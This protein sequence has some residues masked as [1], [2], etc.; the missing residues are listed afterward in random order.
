MRATHILHLGRHPKDLF[1]KSTDENSVDCSC[2]EFSLQHVM[3]FLV[4][5]WWSIGRLHRSLQDYHR[6]WNCLCNWHSLCW[7]CSDPWIP[8]V[9]GMALHSELLGAD[10]YG[11]WWHQTQHCKLRRW[12]NW[13]CYPETARVSNNILFSLLPFYQYRCFDRLWLSD[14]YHNRWAS[15]SDSAARRIL[16]CLWLWGWL[17][18]SGS[19]DLYWLYWSIHNAPGQRTGAC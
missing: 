18:D 15:W 12:S 14:Q 9:I 13:R 8:G 17:Y 10:C 19:I 6:S 16:L 11:N 3:L 1:S 4:H 5:T 7:D 2:L